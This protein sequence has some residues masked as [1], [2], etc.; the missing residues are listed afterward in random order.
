MKSGWQRAPGKE[1][2]CDRDGEE[3]VYFQGLEKEAPQKG[4]AACREVAPRGRQAP[5][6]WPLC[7]CVGPTA[8]PCLLL[9]EREARMMH[10]RSQT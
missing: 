6:E 9:Q 4:G 5:S 8:L 1:T 2:V 7:S 3:G 10:V